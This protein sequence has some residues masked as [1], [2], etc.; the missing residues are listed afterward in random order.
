MAAD[1]ITECQLHNLIL[2][3]SIFP[4][5]LAREK[6]H[7]NCNVW[8]MHLNVLFCTESIY[9]FEDSLLLC[10]HTVLM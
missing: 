10:K 6:I 8:A 9:E 2:G 1:R 4:A 7:C 5:Q 3:R